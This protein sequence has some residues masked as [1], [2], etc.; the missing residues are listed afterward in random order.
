LTPNL[1]FNLDLA[2]QDKVIVNTT[3]KQYQSNAINTDLNFKKGSLELISGVQVIRAKRRNNYGTA[4]K[5]NAGLFFQTN[6][7]AG[8]TLYSVG[9]RKE[10]IDYSFIDTTGDN[11]EIGYDFGV[12]RT[13]NPNLSI[14]SNFNYAFLSPDID[15]WFEYNGPFNGFISPT[16]TQ[17]LNI[18]LNHVTQKN[19]LKATVF[20]MKLQKEQFYNPKNF[21]NTNMDKSHKYG[22]ELQNTY[23][24]SKA[25]STTINYT[26]IQ[27]IIDRIDSSQTYACDDCGWNLPG[28]SD[29]NVTL[30]INYNPTSKS[31]IVFSQNFRSEAYALEDF[32]NG[33]KYT[34]VQKNKAFVSTDIAYKYAHKTDGGK[35]LFNWWPSGP[36]QVD[37]IAKVENLFEYHNGLWLYDNA[38]YPTTFTRNISLGANFNF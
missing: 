16:R 8:N 25:L 38:I 23:N 32:S 9:V 17:T 21:K 37:F 7:D 28:V 4:T 35:S 34:F 27:A 24:H 1:E 29:H 33:S 13:V 11:N 36:R 14:F 15:R 20:G 18:G 30:G 22:F 26:Y 12:N 5:H 10:F 31:R 3:H 2:H 6:Y 19:K